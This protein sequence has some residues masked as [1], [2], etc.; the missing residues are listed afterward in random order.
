MMKSNQNDK[1]TQW[2]L[3]LDNPNNKEV[4]EIMN[5]NEEIKEAIDEL[6]EISK[7]KELRL[8]AELKEKAIRD[9]EI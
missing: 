9:E 2:M 4:L 3:F 6:E 7:D 1:L 8:I 5:K